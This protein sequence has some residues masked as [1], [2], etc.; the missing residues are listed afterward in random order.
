MLAAESY[1]RK[2]YDQLN[3]WGRESSF[4]YAALA[5]KAAQAIQANLEFLMLDYNVP[6]SQGVDPQK[7]GMDELLQIYGSPEFVAAQPNMRGKSD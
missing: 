2:S 6:W 5:V 1:E 3:T 7:K 4:P